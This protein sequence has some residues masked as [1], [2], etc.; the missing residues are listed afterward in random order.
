LSEGY[1]E[2]SP[3]RPF[4]S[5][6]LRLLLV[7]VLV[8]V[9]MLTLLVANG[10]RLIDLYLG[11]S[12]EERLQAQ[13]ASFNITLAGQLAERDYGGLQSVIEG[14]GASKSI[15]YMTVTNSAGKLVAVWG[16][17]VAAPLPEVDHA[18]SPSRG[19]YHGGFDIVFLGQRYGEARYGVDTSF[20]GQARSQLMQ[21]SIF[22]AVVEI[23]LTTLL[24]TAIGYW[25]TRNLNRLTQAALGVAKGDF[26]NRL[27]MKGHDEVAVLTQAFNTMSAAVEARV[28]EA[29]DSRR[30][31]RA[32]A[33][34]TYAWE[35]WFGTDGKLRWVNPAVERVTGYSVAECHAMEDF[36]LP[37]VVEEDRSAFRA[38]LSQIRDGRSAH[39]LEFH[40]RTKAGEIRC[41]SMSWQ[42][43]FDEG[44]AP[45][46]L[47]SSIRDISAHKHSAELMIEAKAELERM[48]FAASH[49]LQE[50][51]RYILA[52]S[53]RLDREMGGE[54]PER[55]RSSMNFIRDGANQLSLLVKGLVDYTRSNRP[56]TAFAPVDCRR[57]VEQA[58]TE[59]KAMASG[60]DA[61]FSV[62]ELPT[63]PADPVLMFIL[64]ENLI[65]NAIKF[66][67]PS[68]I[69]NVVI[70][71]EE[72]ERG[73]RI[74]IADN[75]IG[76]DRQ[77]L[78]SIIRPFSRLHSRSAYPGAGLGL[79]SA[80]KVA[81]IHG[82]RLW[83]DSEPGSGC[84][85][86]VWLPKAASPDVI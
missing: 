71:A 54:M 44:G 14:W 55:A 45:L 10:T 77:Y 22:I 12:M 36:P 70:S 82:G 35:N 2:L 25:L 23:V 79:A 68:T 51:I 74:D 15:S 27:D 64:F 38:A 37:L 46:G 21:Q 49:D 50:P 34:Y 16:R 84:V 57:V 56:V 86:H 11:R 6:R 75:G 30:Q 66:V 32:V 17:P 19:E 4:F 53:Q 41:L 85:V 5:L 63:L 65:G 81:R 48:L 28:R 18:L 13:E 39:D 62:G 1:S 60:V 26:S 8:E 52:Y 9:V 29:E 76:I 3:V 83:L 59:C 42:P 67:P 47:R 33:D 31:F 58:I 61:Q 24:L 40:I 7:S 69:P 43:L 80:Q 20:L 72:D 73:W 78:Q